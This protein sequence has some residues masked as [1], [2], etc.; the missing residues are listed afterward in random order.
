MTVHS[1]SCMYE[2]RGVSSLTPCDAVAHNSSRLYFQSGLSRTQI[3][4]DTPGRCTHLWS[5]IVG[6]ATEGGRGDP[7]ANPLLAHPK[8]GQLTVTFVVQ[9]HIVQFQ[10]PERNQEQR[11]TG[12][13]SI[14]ATR[15]FWT[16]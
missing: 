16:S 14:A 3:S 1:M 11:V 10:V 8:V 13:Q 12:S 7:I 5:N 6:G 2:S 4:K 15:A 9:Q